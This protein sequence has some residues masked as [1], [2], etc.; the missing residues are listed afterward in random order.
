MSGSVLIAVL[1]PLA[2]NGD[3]GARLALLAVALTML[4]IKK[5]LLAISAVLLL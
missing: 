5:L 3:N 4:M 2:I 1:T